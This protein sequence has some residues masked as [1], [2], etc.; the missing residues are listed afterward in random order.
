MAYIDWTP[1]LSVSV[2]QIDE[3]HQRLVA[4]VNDLHQ[5]M[6]QGQGAQVL[7]ETFTKLLDYTKY[8]FSTEEKLFEQYGYPR[9]K[10][11][12]AQ[13][14]DLEHQAAKL[15]ADFDSGKVLVSV[16]VLEFLKEWVT[17]HIMGS[18]KAYSAFFNEAGLH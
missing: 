13:H 12:A 18:D 6:K 5:A 16:Q 4:L 7:A 17:K 10:E 15:Q 2:K 3:Q 1:E 8:H 11:H 14:R 9:A